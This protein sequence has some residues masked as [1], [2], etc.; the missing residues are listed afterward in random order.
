[1][2]KSLYVLTLL[3]K[4]EVWTESLFQSFIQSFEYLDE[5]YFSDPRQGEGDDAGLE[6]EDGTSL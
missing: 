6:F 1:V 5:F 2:G 4:K 3:E